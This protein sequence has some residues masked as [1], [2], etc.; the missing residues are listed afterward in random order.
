MLT[1][2][3]SLIL[4]EAFLTVVPYFFDTSRYNHMDYTTHLYSTA[5]EFIGLRKHPE[6]DPWGFLYPFTPLL[7]TTLLASLLIGSGLMVLFTSCLPLTMKEEN[8]QSAV[9]NCLR[10]LLQQGKIITK[11]VSVMLF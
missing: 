8:H 2:V 1:T 4:Q 5:Y 3:L 7:W 6:V 11:K 10:V 9:H